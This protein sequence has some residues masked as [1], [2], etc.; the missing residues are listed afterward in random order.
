MDVKTR[1]TEKK[2]EYKTDPKRFF[3]FCGIGSGIIVGVFLLYWMW[4]DP[5]ADLGKAATAFLIVVVIAIVTPPVAWI[6]RASP[7]DAGGKLKR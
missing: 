2:A 6:M 1:L 3:R 4:N 5:P 7:D